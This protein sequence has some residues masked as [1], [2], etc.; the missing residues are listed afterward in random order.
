MRWELCIRY[1]NGRERP[2]YSYKSREVA[3]RQ[4]DA[5]YSQ[6]YPL[7]VAYT[8]R[9]QHTPSVADPSSPEAMQPI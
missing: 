1:S 2:L 4:I 8:I 7:H 3:I 5:I 6:G 9:P